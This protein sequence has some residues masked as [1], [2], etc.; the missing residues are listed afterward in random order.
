MP[1]TKQTNIRGLAGPQGPKGETGAPGAV[2]AEGPQGPQGPQGPKGDTGDTG[3]QGAQGPAGA[4]V[5]EGLDVVSEGDPGSWYFDK[6]DE[7][8]GIEGTPVGAIIAFGGNTAPHGWHLCDG[9]AHNSAA[10]KAV[11]GSDTTPD[12][13]GKF[14]LAASAGHPQGSSGGE[15]TH[16]L[17]TGEMPSHGHTAVGVGDHG[18]TITDGAGGHQHTFSGSTDINFS[19]QN[20][21]QF[22]NVYNTLQGGGQRDVD[23]VGRPLGNLQHKH[24][25]SGTTAGGGGHN[26]TVNGGGAHGHSI[27]PS[28]GGA[29]HNNMPP[30]YALTYIIKKGATA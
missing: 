9:S 2:G 11:I 1:W 22:I 13:R 7:I 26:H 30:F 23:G 19:G 15:E 3:P 25:F 14:I 24:D 12:L 29:A 21:A 6:N 17:T 28:G 18:H 4:R 27:E 20:V 5:E 10:L 8:D 16:T